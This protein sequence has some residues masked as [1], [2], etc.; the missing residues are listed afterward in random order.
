M[1]DCDLVHCDVHYGTV[2]SVS[3][4]A[5]EIRLAYLGRAT[6]AAANADDTATVF[7]FDLFAR[8]EDRRE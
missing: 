3:V 2:V 7:L 6:A 1:V 4:V 8:L 5:M